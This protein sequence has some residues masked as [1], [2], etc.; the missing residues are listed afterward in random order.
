MKETVSA[1]GISGGAGVRG[2]AWEE[3]TMVKGD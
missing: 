2:A 3:S 1:V